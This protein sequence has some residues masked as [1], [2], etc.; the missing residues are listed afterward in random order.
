MPIRK[1]LIL[2]L[3]LFLAAI[4]GSAV[5]PGQAH[6]QTPIPLPTITPAPTATPQA[7][8]TIRTFHCNCFGPGRPVSW[9]GYVQAPNYFQASQQAISQCSGYLLGQVQPPQIPMTSGL[10]QPSPT[11]VMLSPCTSCACN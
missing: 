6:A 2:V 1:N 9:A 4:L 10:I 3:F 7:M 11:P 8:S 5:A